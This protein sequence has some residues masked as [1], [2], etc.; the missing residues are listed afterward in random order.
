MKRYFPALLLVASAAV[1]VYGI[2]YLFQLRFE[3]G[4]VYPPY[5]SLRTDPLG[6]MAFYESLDAFP[7]LTVQRD[8]S[9]LNRLPA[10]PDSVY[11]HLATSIPAWRQLSGETFKEIEKFATSGGR[12]L[13]TFY[14]ASVQPPPR[15]ELK[16][17]EPNKEKPKEP[18]AKELWGMDL[19]I[20]NLS[21]S[22][23]TYQ[24]EEARN[25]SGL[26]LPQTLDWHSGI[27]LTD[28]D[29]SWKHIYMRGASPVLVERMFGRGSIVVATDSYFLSN[30]ALALD[31]HADLLS[32]FIGSGRN[33][34]FDEAHLGVVETPG[35]A[36]LMRRY[37]LQWLIAAILLL[38]GLFIWKNSMSLVPPNYKRTTAA[39]V[40]GRDAAAGFV[41]LLR[42]SIPA[43]DL[44]TACFAEWKKSGAQAGGYSSSRIAQAEAAFESENSR[45]GR[46]R[47][48]VRAYQTISNILK[49]HIQ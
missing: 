17:L 10:A 46:D 23:D 5:S 48:A 3:E 33:I 27:V 24:P 41:N 45:T 32:W 22:E 11:L 36:T 26:P 12:L 21:R 2:L 13:V 6:T 20:F 34:M 7:D 40:Q 37:R 35:V 47:D 42:R 29:P 38:A 9:P 8:H 15:P 25:V 31:R 30:E 43:R 4:D 44:L 1:F 39:Y 49:K 28:L 19:R 14:P 18:T 16:G